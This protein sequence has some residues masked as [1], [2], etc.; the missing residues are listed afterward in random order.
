MISKLTILGFQSHRKS[1]LDF[2]P[3]VNVLVGES[4]TGKTAVIRALRWLTW[5]RPQ[6]TKDTRSH[7]A[8]KTIVSAVMNGQSIKLIRRGNVIYK[9]NDLLQLKALRGSVPAEV[10]KAL[11]MNGINLQQQLDAPFLLS[12]SPGEVAQHFNH[13]AHLDVIDR[14][15]QRVRSWIRQLKHETKSLREQIR[16]LKGELEKYDGL[17]GLEKQLVEIEAMENQHVELVE[18]VEGL[19]KTINKINSLEQILTQYQHFGK[20]KEKLEELEEVNVQLLEQQTKIEP[21]QS[22]IESIEGKSTILKLKTA[23]LEEMHERFDREFPEQCP[24]CGRLK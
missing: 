23:D 2:L 1:V 16:G 7:W 17:D 10:Q 12:S 14:A 5:N 4:D 19:E 9:V 15:I 21:L 20:V 3:G 8:K 22:L 6:G 11:N 24:L 18:S 13:I